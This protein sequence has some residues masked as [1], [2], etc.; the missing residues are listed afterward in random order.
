MSNHED[1]DEDDS[2]DDSDVVKITPPPES[3][4][5]AGRILSD[6]NIYKNEDG[7]GNFRTHCKV[8]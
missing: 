7:T 2:D 6:E 1:E 3:E 4:L 5:Q 8:R